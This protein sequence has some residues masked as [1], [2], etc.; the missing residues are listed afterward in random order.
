MKFSRALCSTL[1][2]AAVAAL[3]MSAAQ[4]GGIPSDFLVV[5]PIGG[6]TPPPI[7]VDELAETGAVFNAMPGFDPASLDIPFAL[8]KGAHFVLLT[9]PFGVP[10]EANEV[11]LLVPCAD[12]TGGQQ[13][14]LSDIV[15]GFLDTTGPHVAL[16]S[17]P[18]SLFL[19]PALPG[20][21]PFAVTLEETGTTQD[22][23]T[24]LGFDPAATGLQIGVGSD[25]VPIPAAG[26]L[27]ASGL[28]LL[29]LSRRRI[30]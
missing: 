23:T 10:A 3:S 6:P 14:V 8:S 20:I 24:L 28:G 27:F 25:V 9:E 7:Y 29:G 22:V 1:L 16:Y 17:D 15:V 21:F 11:G 26:W 12:P 19:N 18:H 2:P 13:C 5:G 4:A 30:N